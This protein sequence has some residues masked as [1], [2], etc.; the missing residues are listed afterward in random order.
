MKKSN[1]SLFRIILNKRNKCF[2]ANLHLRNWSPAGVPAATENVTIPDV[3]YDPVIGGTSNAV[4]QSVVVEANA[5][6]DIA[7]D[8]SLTIGGVSGIDFSNYG[9]VNNNGALHIDNTGNTAITNAGN[10]IN[11]SNISIGLNGGVSNIQN[12]GISVEG[13]FENTSS[14]QIDIQNAAF[15]GIVNLYG[16]LDNAG[17]IN[18]DNVQR[19]GINNYGNSTNSDG[20]LLN[21]GMIG[22]A[23][24]IGGD[25]IFNNGPFYNNNGAINIKN[26][27][28]S[29]INLITD[30]LY[31]SGLIN[32]EN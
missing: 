12:V 11:N 13:A 20:G 10:F 17:T 16:T 18:I 14:G 28:G 7:S 4:A 3:I 8:G 19:H 32:T 23:G 6:L 9:V 21:I 2:S 27:T 5:Q 26:S 1:P 24:N 31:T 22:E 30:T 15:D 25:G 29:A